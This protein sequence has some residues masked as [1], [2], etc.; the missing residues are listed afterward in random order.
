MGEFA[1]LDLNRMIDGDWWID[2]VYAPD[3]PDIKT[4]NRCGARELVWMKIKGQWKLSD[5]LGPHVCE[6]NISGFDN[7]DEVRS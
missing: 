3:V 1:E 2:H 7:L 4:C 6:P 5:G